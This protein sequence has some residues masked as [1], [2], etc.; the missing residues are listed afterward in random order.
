MRSGPMDGKL[1]VV[2][3][4]NSGIGRAAAEG[5]A[6][7]GAHVVIACRNGSTAAENEFA[8]PGGRLCRHL[9]LK[10]V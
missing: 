7:Q 10:N 6:R 1:A 5:L 9:A 3:G 2:T 8:G 4:G